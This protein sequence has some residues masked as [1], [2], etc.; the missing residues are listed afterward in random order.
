MSRQE[1]LT[2]MNQAMSSNA[3][4][5]V[6][7]RGRLQAESLTGFGIGNLNVRMGRFLFKRIEITR[8]QIADYP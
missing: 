4:H 2:T 3:H 8:S 1:A 7:L 6:G 5:P